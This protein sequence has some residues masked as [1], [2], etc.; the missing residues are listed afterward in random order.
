MRK[1]M[2]LKRTFLLLISL[3]LILFPISQ[4]AFA[5]EVLLYESVEGFPVTEGVT[6][7]CKTLFTTLGWQKIHILKADLTS[8]NVDIDTLIGKNGI[9]QRSSL[10]NMVIDNNAIA[11]INGDFFMMATPSATIGIQITNG[12]LVSSPCKGNN[13][14]AMGISWDKVPQIMY[15]KHTST[16]IAEN[17]NVFNVDAINE[18]QR[19]TD[20]MSIY[21]P[22]YGKSTPL[23][24]PNI[25]LTFAI[26]KGD[27]VVSILDGKT[28]DI[29]SDGIVIAAKQEGAQFIKDNLQIGQSINLEVK[30]TPDISNLKMAIGAGA[31]LVENGNIPAKFS[32]DI[33]GRHPRTAIGFTADK[34]TIIMVVVDGRQAQSRGMTQTELAKLML[35]LGAF[36][37]VNLDG[38]GSSTMVVRPPGEKLP[39]VINNLSG[40]VQRLI[41]NGVG[42]FSKGADDEI[43]GMRI[44]SESFNIPKDS[45][46]KF[47]VR[48]YDKYYNP[49]DV[50]L[51][52][53]EWQVSN[54]L[55]TFNKNVF[56]ATNTGNGY[57]TAKIGDIT[58]TEKIKIFDKAALI[59]ANKPGV[60]GSDTIGVFGNLLLSPTYNPIYKNNFDLATLVL[61]RS[62]TK[63]NL[64]AGK[65]TSDGSPISNY[66]MTKVISNCQYAGSNYSTNIYKNSYFIFLNSTKGSIKLTDYN[67]WLKLQQDLKNIPESVQNVFIV[68]D[69]APE[70][71]TD[72]L[73]GN[74]LKNILVKDIEKNV[75]VLCGG[76]DKFNAVVDNGVNYLYVPGVDAK[77][78]AVVLLYI[79][80]NEVTYQ[81]VLLNETELKSV[82]V[83]V[84]GKKVNFPDQQPY[85]NENNRTMVPVRFISESLGAE[86]EW[87][88]KNKT[89]IIQ[90]NDKTIKLKIGENKADVNDEII[91]FDT[92]A[93]LKNSRTMVPLRFISEALGAKVNWINDTRTVEIV[94]QD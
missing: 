83:Y 75:W 2:S 82:L 34:K 92:K 88:D 16:L 94:E 4:T 48:A 77:E 47:E 30:T 13:M 59:N 43:Y 60:E 89:V 12:K 53:V 87:D 22:E 20:K 27:T 74:L 81:T 45:S 26:T 35:D 25:D 31:V 86:V 66:Q 84:N 3:M 10:S 85:I 73:E 17:G 72:T 56:T 40:G 67:Q 57:I 15:L 62:N 51:E 19:E 61:N 37:A 5:Q 39:Q 69:K 8:D 54:N 78:P 42:I 33:A 38:G 18:L 28:V 1:F 14:A 64:I 93:E 91:V 79:N 71:F 65:P 41:P 44:V 58:A 50:D 6:Y 63:M 24:L 21:T 90:K 7:E 49:L 32:H 11:G 23:N 55:G 36:N 46:R 29:P 70:N 76:A 52:E 9:S 68:M 80:D